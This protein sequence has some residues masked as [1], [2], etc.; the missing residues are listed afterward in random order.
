MTTPSALSKDAFGDIFLM[1][2]LPSYS[3]R[4]LP[5]S[6]PPFKQPILYARVNVSPWLRTTKR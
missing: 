4:G 1:R 2:S 5:L 3:R 6:G